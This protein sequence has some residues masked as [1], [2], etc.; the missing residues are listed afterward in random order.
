MAVHKL[1]SGTPGG[2]EEILKDGPSADLFL[3]VRSCEK[4]RSKA[5]KGD[6]GGEL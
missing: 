5:G 6:A 2:K 3:P 4:S 1:T